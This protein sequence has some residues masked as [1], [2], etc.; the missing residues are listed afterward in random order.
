MTCEEFSNE[1][2]VLVSSYKRFKDFDNK[3]NLDSIEFNEYE[4]SVFL[5][6]AQEELVI[7]LYNGFNN[8]NTS[9]EKTEEVRRILNELVNTSLLEEYTEE[10]EVLLSDYSKIFK[11]PEN[12]WFITYESVIFN[13]PFMECLNGT[14]SL[15]VPV[16]QDELY[17]ILKNP[18]RGPTKNRVLRL[19]RKNNIVE[20]ISKYNIKNYVLRYLEKPNPIILID[21]PNE[22]NING[23]NKKTECILNSSIH[24]KILELAVESALLS[25]SVSISKHNE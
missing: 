22:L 1:F 11:L 12:V 7:S 17:K 18:F 4:K 24:R 8:N 5:T 6:K 13:E 21:L 3:E 20:L 25:K 10:S 16:S 23:I 2:D 9:F 15:V 14:T 19:D